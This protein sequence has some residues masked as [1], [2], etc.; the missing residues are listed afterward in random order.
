MVLVQKGS[1]LLLLN[2]G[3]SCS[4]GTGG[5]PAFHNRHAVL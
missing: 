5:L 2:N 3:I 4:A 1:F